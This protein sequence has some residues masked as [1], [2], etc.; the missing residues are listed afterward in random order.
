MSPGKALA[1]EEEGLVGTSL[2]WRE[3]LEGAGKHYSKVQV[4]PA[5]ESGL[6][7]QGW[8]VLVSQSVAEQPQTCPLMSCDVG[9]GGW[10]PGWAAEGEH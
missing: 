2:R 7:S 6:C 1:A 4:S 5:G 9:F 10:L 3:V 8:C